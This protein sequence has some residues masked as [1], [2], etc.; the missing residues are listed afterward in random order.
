MG[1]TCANPQAANTI[2][3]P[4]M[5]ESYAAKRLPHPDLKAYKTNFERDLFMVINLL[6]ENPLSFQ[7]YVSNYVKK[8]KFPGDPNAANTL[9]RRFKSLDKLEATSL[10]AHASNACYLNLSKNESTPANITTG[11]VKELKTT[12]NQL[13]SSHKCFDS[14]KRKWVGSALELVLTFLLGYYERQPDTATH[15]FLDSNLK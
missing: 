5:M 8:G 7:S 9:I 14:Y 15:S 3:I 13:V 10:N 2:E 11:A 4:N 1:A 6:R 12:E